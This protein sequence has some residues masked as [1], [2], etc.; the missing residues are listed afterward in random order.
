MRE[1]P[2]STKT[3]EVLGNPSPT[4]K[5]GLEGRGK[6]R[7]GGARIQCRTRIPSLCFE[8]RTRISFF[9]FHASRRE[10]E[11]RLRQFL[12]ICCFWTDIF[13]ENAVNF[14]NFLSGN[15]N[16]NLIFQAGMIISFFESCLPRR[17]Y[18]SINLVFHLNKSEQNQFEKYYQHNIYLLV[19]ER[20]KTKVCFASQVSVLFCSEKG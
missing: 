13:K 17:E 12:Q 5:R 15:L 19:N 14:S 4:A 1:C 6:S 10:R 9:Q 8:T 18:L 7:F 3:L 16:E 11:S 2:Y 20:K